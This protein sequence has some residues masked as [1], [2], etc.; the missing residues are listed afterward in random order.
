MRTSMENLPRAARAPDRSRKPASQGNADAAGSKEEAAEAGGFLS[1]LLRQNT[2]ASVM[3]VAKPDDPSAGIPAEA[4]ADAKPLQLA[5]LT[6]LLS[7]GEDGG[8]GA[9]TPAMPGTGILQK[10]LLEPFTGKAA[11]MVPAH[12]GSGSETGLLRHLAGMPVAPAAPAD[13][14]GNLAAL[15]L[16]K[17]LASAGEGAAETFGAEAPVTADTLIEALVRRVTQAARPESGAEEL[18]LKPAGNAPEPVAPAPLLRAES[19]V[20][21]PAQPDRSADVHPAP[22]ANPP[23]APAANPPPAPAALEHLQT[24]TV[25]NVRY[26]MANGQRTVSV[27]LV[28]ESLGEMRIEVHGNSG[29][30]SVRLV[31]ASPLVREALESQLAALRENFAKEGIRVEHIEVS[32]DLQRGMSQGGRFNQQP[33]G[34]PQ[35]RLPRQPAW[36]G[37]PETIPAENAAEQQGSAAHRGALNLFV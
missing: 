14:A 9:E 28:P 6:L 2:P 34:A 17:P 32:P 15:L 35:H 37:R 7:A 10:N 26:L 1:L 12:A 13:S 23:P 16:D 24:H 36:T 33:D 11:A 27:R 25:K 21:S 19:P 3:A 29:D 4:A 18:T 8:N 31:S 30:V 22:A 20:L 5:G